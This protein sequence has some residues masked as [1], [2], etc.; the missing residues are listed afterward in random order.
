MSW[1][2]LGLTKLEVMRN[3]IRQYVQLLERKNN[4]NNKLDIIKNIINSQEKIADIKNEYDLETLFSWED[5]WRAPYEMIG[6][7]ELISLK[8]ELSDMMIEDKSA[9]ENTTSGKKGLI[10]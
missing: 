3:S 7:V 2:G 1:K 9:S 8:R 10:K 6:T 4:E 5:T